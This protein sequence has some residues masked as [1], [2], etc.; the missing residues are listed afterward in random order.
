MSD[1]D[2]TWIDAER[3]IRFGPTTVAEAPAL[4]AGRGFEDYALLTT[5]RAAAGAPALTEAAGAVLNVPD[6]PVPE[7]AASVR[8]SVGE[9]PVVALGGGRVIDAA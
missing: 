3:L 6:G 1:R 8:S 7:A 9:R 4:L 5:E 2:F